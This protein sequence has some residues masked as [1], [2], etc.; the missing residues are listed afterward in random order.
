MW[1][2][3]LKLNFTRNRCAQSC[4]Y[5][6]GVA[7]NPVLLTKF[8]TSPCSFHST[9]VSDDQRNE[10]FRRVAA[11]FLLL[12]LS[13][14]KCNCGRTW[15]TILCSI[16]SIL[17]GLVCIREPLNIER[18]C[19]EQRTRTKQWIAE[20]ASLQKEWIL[21]KVLWV[22]GARKK[23]YFSWYKRKKKK[24][25]VCHQ[26]ALSPS[27]SKRSSTCSTQGGSSNKGKSQCCC[28]RF[29]FRCC[30][31][32]CCFGCCFGCCCCCCC[33]CCCFGCWQQHPKATTNAGLQSSIP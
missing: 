27:Y 29:R 32:C 3:S 1:I 2:S 31:C 10:Y 28:F 30:C 4:S 25:V 26:F 13:S 5:L 15:C 21:L 24:E 19:H 9:R 14:F 18:S 11:F 22:P 33:C 7:T 12:L 6:S 23:R 20:R 17:C 16:I 8:I